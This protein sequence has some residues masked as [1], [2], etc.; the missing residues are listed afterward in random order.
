ML[1]IY[2]PKAENEVWNEEKQEFEYPHFEGQKLQLE[3]SLVSISKWEMKYNK[4]FLSNKKKTPEEMLYYVKC[5]T[6]TKNVPDE[7][8][9]Y[10]TKENFSKISEYTNARLTATYVHTPPK[11]EGASGNNVITSEMIYYWMITFNIPFECQ[12]WPL[13][14]LLALINICTAKAEEASRKGKSGKLSR[15]ALASRNAVNA[16]RRAAIHSNG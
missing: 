1:T 9:L 6:I 3:H 16:K 8:Y 15:K 4:A 13:Q 7:A 2:I 12:K 10:L 11:K 5:M 14:R